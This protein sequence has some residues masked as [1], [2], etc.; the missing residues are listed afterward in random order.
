[1]R[2]GVRATRAEAG[3]VSPSPEV[4]FSARPAEAPR[5]DMLRRKVS[6]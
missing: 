1:L 5:A 2:T 3:Y 6:R 4:H